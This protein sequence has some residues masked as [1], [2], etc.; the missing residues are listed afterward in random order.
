MGYGADAEAKRILG[1]SVVLRGGKTNPG[2]QKYR[3]IAVDVP[4][5]F[6]KVVPFTCSKDTSPMD[7]MRKMFWSSLMVYYTDEG[8]SRPALPKLAYA[9]FAFD[10][11]RIPTMRE[12]FY[13]ERRYKADV[14]DPSASEV[15]VGDRIFLRDECPIADDLVD[16]ITA[17]NMPADWQC[18]WNSHK[19]KSKLWKVLVECLKVV[20]KENVGR[21]GGTFF[22]I[23]DNVGERWVYPLIDPENVNRIE[24]GMPELYY[25]EADQKVLHMS[26][27]LEGCGAGP[28]LLVTIDWDLHLTMVLHNADVDILIARVFTS[29]LDPDESFV[30]DPDRV[31]LTKASVSKKD[32][33]RG[34]TI[35]SFEII[36]NSVILARY[37]TLEK[38][39]EVVMIMLANGGVD[40]CLGLARFGFTKSPIVK[41]LNAYKTKYG[42]KTDEELEAERFEAA[43]LEERHAAML[44]DGEEE[45]DSEDERVEKKESFE[46]V[47]PFI[48]LPVDVDDV[49]CRHMIF[50]TA[51]FLA[52][53]RVVG[54]KRGSKLLNA[55][56]ADV[57]K[58][59][60]DMLWSLRYFGG[61]DLQLLPGGPV[62][63]DYT[64]P[65][66][67]CLEVNSGE[68]M[69]KV[70]PKLND[71]TYK[72]VFAEDEPIADFELWPHPLLTSFSAQQSAA[73]VTALGGA[74]ALV[75]IGDHYIE[76]VTVDTNDIDDD[77]DDDDID[78]DDAGPA[79]VNVAALARA[80]V[81]E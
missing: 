55:K 60:H 27:Y 79:V 26:L 65:A 25:G 35:N 61:W 69:A 8:F 7:A 49:A 73:I 64:K 68:T 75:E 24:H 46:W 34:G 10:D 22:M 38:R 53:C 28:V 56:C 43:L 42:V 70:Y 41:L 13:Q 21:Y 2:Y 31:A 78:D 6:R 77:D 45:W 62:P 66:F 5:W 51:A 36:R 12:R 72:L 16:K 48:T 17:H 23:D 18:V 3:S 81:E 40:Y 39:Y 47:Q 11:G 14:G 54:P 67:K 32:W 9:V 57:N 20:I 50:D 71:T 63:P 15:R 19:G 4:A 76:R 58:E 44:V 29:V 30:F 37:P 59:L 33:A 74:D 1:G 80:M 52:N